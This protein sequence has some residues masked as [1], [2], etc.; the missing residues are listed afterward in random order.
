MIQDTLSI[1]DYLFEGLSYNLIIAAYIMAGL[2]LLF[3]WGIT[4]TKGIART[5]NKTPNKFSWKHFNLRAKIA[6]IVVTLIALFVLFRFTGQIYN[7]ELSMFIAF[8]GGLGIDVVISK[9][10]ILKL[11]K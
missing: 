5:D 9:I 1:Q 6:S 11:K 4:V 2:G 8:V 7:M 3:R 10:S